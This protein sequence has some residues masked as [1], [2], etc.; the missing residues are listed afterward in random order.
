MITAQNGIEV[1][2]GNATLDGNIV[3]DNNYVIPQ[4]GTA[5]GA[6][7]ILIFT[8]GVKAENNT[9][10]DSN[11]DFYIQGNFATLTYNSMS[12]SINFDHVDLIGS[13]NVVEHNVMTH[14]DQYGVYICGSKNSIHDNTINEAAYGIF[15]DKTSSGCTASA[16][17]SA[18]DNTLLNVTTLYTPDNST[19]PNLTPAVAST[20]HAHLNVSPFRK[21]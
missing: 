8:N 2:S 12:K 17:N 4:G 3:S 16:S 20:P 19:L 11:G 7:N 10:T 5:Y 15:E 1:D 18:T 13:H 21:Q 9:S 14:A 6:T